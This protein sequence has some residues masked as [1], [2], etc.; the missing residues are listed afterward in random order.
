MKKYLKLLPLILYPYMYII[1]FLGLFVCVAILSDSFGAGNILKNFA[2]IFVIYHVLAF[3]TAVYGAVM[4]AGN[5]SSAEEAAKMNLI[6]KVCH[7]P[8][9]IFYFIIGM[10]SLLLSIWG[11][12][13]ILLA[14]VVDVMTIVLTGINAIGC[15]VKMK[16]ENKL[17]TLTAVLTGI[18]SFLFCIDVAIAVWY[19]FVGKKS[20]T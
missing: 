7:I 4:N 5:E 13:F 10:S 11:L 19:V 1:W 17:T 12:G 15:A 14:V 20:G 18:G 6:V 3:M 2:I 16:K 9:Y 8:A